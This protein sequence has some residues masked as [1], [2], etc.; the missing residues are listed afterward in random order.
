MCRDGREDCRRLGI[1]S[2]FYR[3]IHDYRCRAG[4]I[5]LYRS[6]AKKGGARGIQ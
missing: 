1:E 3:I 5:E 4:I 2:P 6:A